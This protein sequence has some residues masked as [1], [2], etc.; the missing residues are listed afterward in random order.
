M[1]SSIFA[2][3][4]N[5]DITDKLLN[6]LEVRVEPFAICDVRSGSYLDVKAEEC[7]TIH[8]TLAGHGQIVANRGKAIQ[9]QT[10]QIILIPPGMSQHIESQQLA[11]N[12]NLGPSHCLK[13]TD[14]LHW[15]KAGNGDTDIILACGRIH[16]TYGQDVDIFGLLA[17]PIV[18]SFHDSPYIRGAFEAI[19]HEF[20]SP[21]LGTIALT[22]TLMKQCLILLL[23]R[24]HEQQDWRIPWLSVLN[25]PRLEGPL[26]AMLDAPE[27]NHRVEDLAELAFMSRSSFTEHFTKTFGQP[28]HDF[29]TNYRLR[30]AAQLLTTS[31]L[32]I[33]NVADK[34]GYQSRSSF[35]RAFKTMYGQDPA[36]YRKTMAL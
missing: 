1:A 8:Y 19:L 26:R 4:N 29:L 36:S 22:S 27:K 33:K 7:T 35:S 28:P 20:G 10:D 9:L 13:P 17:E 18:E 34:V 14:G 15:L 24:L 12:G 3:N 11:T 23:R 5:M 6:A 32:P 25:N 31:E 2:H 16:V 30:R 21:K